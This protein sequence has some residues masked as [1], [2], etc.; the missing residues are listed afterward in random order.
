MGCRSKCG[1]K[2]QRTKGPTQIQL[3]EA[4]VPK[5]IPPGTLLSSFLMVVCPLM[6]VHLCM[7]CQEKIAIM[8]RYGWTGWRDGKGLLLLWFHWYEARA[9]GQIT[10]PLV[11]YPMLVFGVWCWNWAWVGVILWSW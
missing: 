5:L 2:G 9:A 1:G 3:K 8:N 6:A 11:N 10:G 7:E 4:P